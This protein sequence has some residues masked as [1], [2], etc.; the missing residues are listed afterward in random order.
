MKTRWFVP[1]QREDAIAG[2]L[3]SE[4]HSLFFVG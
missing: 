3:F 1:K 2:N 4:G